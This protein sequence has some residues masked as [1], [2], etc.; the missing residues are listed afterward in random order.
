MFGFRKCTDVHLTLMLSLQGPAKSGSWNNLNLHCCAVFPT[1]QH[2][3]N[4]HAWWMEEI[5][6]AKRL[7]QAF[8]HF[9]TAQVYSQTIKYQVYQYGPNIVMSKFMSKPWTTLQ[10]IQFLLLQIDGHQYMKLR[11]CT[12][13]KY[14][15]LRVRN[16]FLRISLHDLPYH[17]TKKIFSVYRSS[18]RSRGQKTF[19]RTLN[20][21]SFTFS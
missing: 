8:V 9:V 20:M 3:L 18:R 10:L 15:C 4:S 11:L 19:I 16:M 1:S 12:I 21:L 6:R 7:P 5:K 13:V 17:R 14:N 2:C